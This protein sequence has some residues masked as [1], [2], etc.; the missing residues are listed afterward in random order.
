MIT[1]QQLDLLIRAVTAWA[2]YQEQRT[3]PYT[4]GELSRLQRLLMD[5]RYSLKTREKVYLVILK[6]LKLDFT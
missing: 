3:A 5:A 4:D 2:E 6:D 1:E